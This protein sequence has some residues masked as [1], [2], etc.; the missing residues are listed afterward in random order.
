MRPEH[1]RLV[2]QGMAGALSATVSHSVYFGTDSHVHL[3]LLDG[4]EVVARLQTDAEGS[5]GP[6]PGTVVGISF[7]P[8]SIQ[9]L[10]D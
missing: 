7:A 6:K 4:T 10:E 2:S 9:V 1:L 3:T 5:S 8:G